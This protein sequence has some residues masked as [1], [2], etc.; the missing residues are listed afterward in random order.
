MHPNWIGLICAGLALVAFSLGYRM[1]VTRTKRFRILLAILLIIWA[2]PGASFASY[3]AH[4]FQEPGWYYEFR[5]WRGSECVLI[6]LGL[7][8]G[9]VASLLPRVLLVIPLLGVALFAF[10]PFL[11]PIIG[12]IPDDDLRDRWDGEICL[13]STG[14][15]CGAASVA[16][17]LRS[18]GESVTERQL[19]RDAYS[20]NAGTEVWYLARAVRARG[21]GTRFIISTGFDENIPLPALAG[22][23]LG[24]VGHFIAILSRDGDRFRVGEPCSGMRILSPKELRKQYTFTGFYMPVTKKRKI[25]SNGPSCSIVQDYP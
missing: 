5:S 20:Y 18:C 6:V 10:V 25:H 7:A 2:I 17:I 15:T 14:S 24:G 21:L 4:V 11:K 3:Y 19:A 23:R 16:T 1:A 8:G 22:V 12:P 13:Q 9:L